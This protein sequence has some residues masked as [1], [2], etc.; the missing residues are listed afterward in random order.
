MDK[1]TN[2]ITRLFLGHHKCASQY[3]KLVMAHGAKLLGWKTKVEGLPF[4]LPMDFHL[5]E[6]F[7]T[8]LNEK[9]TMLAAGPYD[10][11]CL[12]NADNEGVAI[13]DQSRCWRGVHVIRDPRDVLVSGYFSHRYSH[14]VSEHESPWLWSWREQWQSLDDHRQGL[15]LELDHCSTYFVRLRNW[16]YSRP[17]VLEVK[18]ES[19][20]VDPLGTFTAIWRF[21][22]VEV[23]AFAP[24]ATSRLLLNYV[25]LLA[26]G[27]A[28]ARQSVLPKSTLNAIIR[29]NS[30]E[31]MSGG[32][33]R[34]EENIQN[35]Y[36][37]GISGDWK[38]WF[39]PALKEAFKLHYPTLLETLGYENDDRW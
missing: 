37:K 8:R 17:N 39:T 34:G 18:Y 26:N 11:I 15:M 10:L 3:V 6:P 28:V 19:L 1:R 32:R 35:H 27:R 7:L 29:R 31:R 9:R 14:P 33:R 38:N 2:D 22:G 5:R 36:R 12:E 13:L 20:T 16:N 23:P 4:Q 25:G 21:L 30:F 24:F